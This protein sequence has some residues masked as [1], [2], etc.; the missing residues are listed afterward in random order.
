MKYLKFSLI[1]SSSLFM[2]WLMFINY[3]D[4]H[5]VNI[6]RNHLSGETTLDSISGFNLS[7]PWVQI[8]SIDTRPIREFVSH[9][10]HETSIVC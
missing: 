3:T 4:V 2:I 6:R 7:W 10:P 1:I 9:H 5:E 8:I